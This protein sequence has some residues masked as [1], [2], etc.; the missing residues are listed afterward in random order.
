MIDYTDDHRTADID[1]Y[2]FKKDKKTGYYLSTSRI[3]ERRKR[4]HVYI[5]EKHNGV[6]PKGFQVHHVDRNKDNNEIE[7]LVLL[8]KADHLKQHASTPERIK[9]SQQAIKKAVLFAPEWHKSDEGHEWHIKHGKDSWK[10]RE[11]ISYICTQCGNSFKSLKAYSENENRFCSNNCKSKFRRKMGY[12]NV[13]RKCEECDNTFIVNR[14]QKRR[15]CNECI[16]K[17]RQENGKR[18]CLQLHGKG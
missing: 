5:W 14:Y 9:A 8:S 12:D 6:I 3:G 15:L 2:K 1:G 11:P 10:N 13:E 7:N 17:K 16:S 4:L 18:T